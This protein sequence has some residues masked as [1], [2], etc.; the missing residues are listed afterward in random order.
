M[1]FGTSRPEKK[2]QNEALLKAKPSLEGYERP[3]LLEK[4]NA[5]DLAAKEFRKGCFRRQQSSAG[6]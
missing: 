2:P 6:V 4:L 3:D 1:V 5:T